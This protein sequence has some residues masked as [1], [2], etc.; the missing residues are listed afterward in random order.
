MI[1]LMKRLF[2]VCNIYSYSIWESA[3][4]GRLKCIQNPSNQ[5]ISSI[6]L[7]GTLKSK[8][9]SYF[10]S[11]KLNLTL[12]ICVWCT[13]PHVDVSV[14]HVKEIWIWVFFQRKKGNILFKIISYIFIFIKKNYLI[15]FKLII[16]KIIHF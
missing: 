1:I 7:F 3:I 8:F 2:Q 5:P 16:I 15:S 12:L 10:S 4:L 13:L 9:S 6:K 11:I 14:Y